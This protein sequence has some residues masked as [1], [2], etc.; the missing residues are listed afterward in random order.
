MSDTKKI[1]DALA[2]AQMCIYPDDI[3]RTCEKIMGHTSEATYAYLTLKKWFAD[4]GLVTT[5]LEFRGLPEYKHI[6]LSLVNACL[7]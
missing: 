7:E 5:Y 6:I 4:R 1:L 3:Q 2:L